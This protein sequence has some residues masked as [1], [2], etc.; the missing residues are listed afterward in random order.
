MTTWSPAFVGAGRQSI[1]ES[2]S[3]GVFM[4]RLIGCGAKR[5]GSTPIAS[6]ARRRFSSHD[7][8]QPSTPRPR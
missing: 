2:G 3:A 1:V 6:S 7:A 4:N 8:C 5:G